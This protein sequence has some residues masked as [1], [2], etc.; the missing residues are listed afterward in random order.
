MPH[1][2]LMPL[3]IW[4][5]C[6]LDRIAHIADLFALVVGKGDCLC[7][8]GDLGAG[9]TTLATAFL[10]AYADR[11][12]LTV[13]SP[14]FTLVERY[15]LP[16][17][18]VH[19]ADLYRLNDPEEIY[20]LGLE[21]ALGEGV[22]LVEWPR[23]G[24][25]VIPDDAVTLH[26]EIEDDGRRCITVEGGGDWCERIERL[27][28]MEEFLR[29]TAG[30]DARLSYMQGDASARRYARV[31][32]IAGPDRIL[33]DSP[34]QPDGPPVE[35]GKPYSAIA[36]L[37]EDIAPFVA[38]SQ[39]LSAC[40]LSVPKV[41]AADLDV[42]FALIEDLG[43]VTFGRAIDEGACEAELYGAAIDVLAALAGQLAPREIAMRE[44]ASKDGSPVRILLPEFDWAAF[45]IEAS[46]FIQWY[47]PTAVGVATS[48][49]IKR[50][51]G[52][53]W[54]TLFDQLGT[55]ESWVLRDFHSPN[56]IWRRNADGL[57]RIG[58]IDF[59]DAMRGHA[60]YD[61]VSLLQDARRDVPAQLEAE[62]LSRYLET[63]QVND[64]DAFL[65]AYA[66]LGAQRATKILGIFARLAV[67]DGKPM[68]LAHLP[69]IWGYLE[70]NLQHEGLALLR[71]WYDA[72]VPG[73]VRQALTPT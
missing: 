58:V 10:R 34:R 49:A 7:L 36:H 40:G 72:N 69:R 56:L 35:D 73:V 65:R 1:P 48:T 57:A 30:A 4:R 11:P 52:E 13:P 61:L 39:A 5:G 62:L 53:I 2:R 60:A 44:Y 38:I 17:G 29:G 24:C 46:L 55:Q 42:G 27:S 22:L 64:A 37:A 32:G 18:I 19:H 23:I 51:F 9:K 20:E 33:M 8:E 3:K 66:I 68:Y 26:F 54:A 71:D 50:A 43:D 16:R 47:L 25:A 21:D 14:T 70:R 28:R 12:D 63:A 15:D 59:Q 31:R 6:D 45:R 67:R 41:F